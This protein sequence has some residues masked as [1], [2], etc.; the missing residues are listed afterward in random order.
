MSL[1]YDIVEIE[2]EKCIDID[3][4]V[5]DVNKE[6]LECTGEDPDIFD[7]EDENEF[8]S[9]VDAAVRLDYSTN[10][11]VKMLR[12]ILDY[13][14]IEKKKLRKTDM[15][16]RIIEFENDYNN[17]EIVEKRKYLWQMMEELKNDEYMSKFVIFD[18]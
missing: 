5:K 17:I 8:G 18:C 1:T 3:A 6:H 15:V 14:K 2:K 11:T 7:D 12:H 9:S 13:Y 16:D 10:Y 4:L